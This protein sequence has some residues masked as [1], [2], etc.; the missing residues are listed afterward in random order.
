MEINEVRAVV[1]SLDGDLALV[2]VEQGGCGRCHEKGGCG[3][4]HL[5]Q[6]FCSASKR[7]QV[8]NVPGV[9]VGD[10]VTIGIPA[11]AVRYS[12]NLVYVLP[13]LSI[14]VGALSGMHYA[15]DS[16]AMF[17]GLIGLI[18]AWLII[19]LKARSKAGNPEFQPQIIS[20]TSIHR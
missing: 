17:G 20:P 9:Q 3:G 13:V 15:G 8:K 5:T 12:A 4:Q 1:R 7:Y 11:G 14:F 19:R 16:G 10:Q 18:S 6:A 2:E